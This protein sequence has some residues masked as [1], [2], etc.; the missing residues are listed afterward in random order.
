M[1][2]PPRLPDE[3]MNR[4]QL[5][6]DRVHAQRAMANGVTRV[7]RCAEAHA[8]YRADVWAPEPG[9]PYD[10]GDF[11]AMVRVAA[12]GHAEHDLFAELDDPPSDPVHVT[13]I[14]PQWVNTFRGYGNPPLEAP[15]WA[16]TFD[17]DLGPGSFPTIATA[18]AV[19][20]M[21][22]RP[23][24]LTVDWDWAGVFPFG[25]P[26]YTAPLPEGATRAVAGTCENDGEAAA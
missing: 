15:D 3:V 6:A 2:F 10:L 11:L 1:E 24:L 5:A 13:V 21:G 22:R 12:Q 8:N 14:A 4:L 16:L 20:A 23:N 19:A 25:T 9:R 17:H 26:N 7:L 18:V